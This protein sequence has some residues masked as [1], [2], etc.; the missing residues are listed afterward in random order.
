M[1]KEKTEK[2][3]N[4]ENKKHSKRKIV[5]IVLL[6]LFLLAIVGWGAFSIAMYEENF[7]QR[8][9][10]YEPLS[11]RV[12]DFEGLSR[13]KYEFPSD[14]GQKL[15]G[16]WYSAGENQRGI[17]VIAHG[18]G[19]GGHNSYM[20]VANYFAQHGY[21]VFAYDATG[22]DES[23]GEGVGGV[24]QGQ[25]DLN[26]AISFVEES[27]NFP[28]LPIGLFGHSWG[29]YSVCSVLTFHPEVRAVI[30]CSGGNASADLFEGGGKSQAGDLI[31]TM[32]PFI[33]LHEW[34]H[35]GKYATNTAL[36]GFEAS[37]AAVM[38]IHSEDDSVVSIEYGLDKYYEKYKD[39]P[40]FVFKR[41]KDKGH[42]YIY[43]DMTY[44]DSFN[45]EFDKWLQ[46]L[47]YDYKA[48]EN[49]ERFKKDKADYIHAHLDRTKWANRLNEEM[50]REFLAFYDKNLG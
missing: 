39:D 10:S 13:T 22:N 25:I 1:K 34:L 5:G 35:Y 46:T 41:L 33:N 2:T 37:D 4:K 7:N 19:G 16:Y 40:R 15:A 47:H 27:G 43:N 49:K 6:S 20:D 12:E 44:I 11:F 45:V 18:F 36:D 9:E 29:G 17:I 21:Y 28:K 48:E 26:Y 32:M 14:K 31:Y 24:P 8:F 3:E 38:V 42:N 23:E 50:F 30:E